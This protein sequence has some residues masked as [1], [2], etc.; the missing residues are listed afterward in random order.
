MSWTTRPADQPADLH[1]LVGALADL[2][3]S[4]Q[5][6]GDDLHALLRQAFPNWQTAAQAAAAVLVA[7][8]PREPA[9]TWLA[10]RLMA[11]I[12]PVLSEA[13]GVQ[14]DGTELA[15]IF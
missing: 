4:L 12:A 5:H 15:P 3:L 13:Y 6:Q 1:R 8:V 14:L 2:L 7:A 9:P 11:G 10:A